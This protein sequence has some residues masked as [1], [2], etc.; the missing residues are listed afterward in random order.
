VNATRP[1]ANSEIVDANGNTVEDVAFVLVSYGRDRIPDHAS[2]GNLFDPVVP[3]RL[4]WYITAGTPPDFFSAKTDDIYL[5][6]TFPELL[7]VLAREGQ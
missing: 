4:A 5:A 1:H 7:S 2:Y 3:T 6:V